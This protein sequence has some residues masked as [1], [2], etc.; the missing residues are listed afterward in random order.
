VL[1][2]LH[3]DHRCEIALA[4]DQ[5]YASPAEPQSPFDFGLILRLS[6]F[7]LQTQARGSDTE[8]CR[9]TT[10][11]ILFQV[12]EGHGGHAKATFVGRALPAQP[13]DYTPSG[14]G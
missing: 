13:A 3:A 8:G 5:W 6:L 12:I 14:I 1:R 10:R 4:H 2:L 11:A 7:Q 9:P